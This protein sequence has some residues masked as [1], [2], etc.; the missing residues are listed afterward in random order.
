MTILILIDVYFDK[1]DISFGD[2]VHVA[3]QLLPLTPIVK[4]PLSKTC[5]HAFIHNGTAF[6]KMEA[7]ED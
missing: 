3:S 6:V 2:F 7:E 1:F 5:Y 4:S